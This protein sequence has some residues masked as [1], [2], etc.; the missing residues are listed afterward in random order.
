MILTNSSP[1][2][3]PAFEI[4]PGVTLHANHDSNNTII[5]LEKRDPSKGLHAV[6]LVMVVRGNLCKALKEVLK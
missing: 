4:A 5:S 2:P 1:P 6:K 3:L